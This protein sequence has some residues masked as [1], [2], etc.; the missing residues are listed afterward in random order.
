MPPREAQ[1]RAICTNTTV[2]GRD[3]GVLERM[4]HT[5]ASGKQVRPDRRRPE[6]SAEVRIA[7][8][9]RACSPTPGGTRR[10]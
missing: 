10:P 7:A 4:T 6:G 8:H 3:P 2:P 9:V 1:A 5:P